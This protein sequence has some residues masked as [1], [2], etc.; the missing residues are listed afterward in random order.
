V[1][2]TKRAALFE[3]GLGLYPAS[4]FN[5]FLF[6]KMLKSACVYTRA[7]LATSVAACQQKTVTIYN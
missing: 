6:L 2:L 4:Y 3:R 7:L 1:G 5:P